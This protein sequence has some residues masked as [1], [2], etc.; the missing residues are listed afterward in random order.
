MILNIVKA[1][2]IR[3]Y[4]I[5]I[6][7]NDG[8]EKTIDLKTYIKEKKHPFFQPLK[9]VDE[10]KKFKVHKTLFWDNGADIAAEFLYN[11]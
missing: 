1:D 2:Y 6:Y 9:Q 7:F 4:K 11:L 8:L 5:K 3:D 10:F